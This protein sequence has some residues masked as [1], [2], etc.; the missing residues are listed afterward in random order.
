ML[1][2]I[3]NDWSLWSRVVWYEPCVSQRHDPCVNR[4]AAPPFWMVLRFANVF[5]CTGSSFE[6][7]PVSESYANVRAS[8][9]L[10]VNAGLYVSCACQPVTS[11][12]VQAMRV[13]SEF[14]VLVDPVCWSIVARLSGSVK[15]LSDIW[16][17]SACR[18]VCPTWKSAETLRPRLPKRCRSVSRLE[19]LSPEVRLSAM[20]AAELTSEPSSV[21]LLATPLLAVWTFCR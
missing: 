13:E 16:S 14:V 5:D 6:K 2:V 19:T 17:R 20:L 15:R 9:L 1:P 3:G 7:S 4:T 18:L 21:R 8:E 12:S 10:C 11:G